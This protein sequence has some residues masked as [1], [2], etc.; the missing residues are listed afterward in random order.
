MNLIVDGWDV[1]PNL[2]NSVGEK[3]SWFES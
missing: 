3:R 2:C 1:I